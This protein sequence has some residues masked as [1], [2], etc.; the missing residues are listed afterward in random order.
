MYAAMAFATQAH[1]RFGVRREPSTKMS[2]SILSSC[3]L[4]G[5]SLPPVR[6]STKPTAGGSLPA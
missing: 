5:G 1:L 3:A 6:R 2:A 4:R